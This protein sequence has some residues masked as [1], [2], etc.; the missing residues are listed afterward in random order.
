VPTEQRTNL[1][2]IFEDRLEAE[3]A[4]DELEQAGFS[5][6]EV[7][8]AIRGSDV[9]AGGMITDEE[10]A[11]DARGAAAGMATGAGV[12]AVL[13]AAAALLVPGVGPVVAAGVL[14]MAFG[15]AI[16]GT[17]IGGIFGALTGLDVSEDEARLY[18]HEFNSGKA[19]VAVKAATR[20]RDAARILKNHGGYDLQN[21]P[22]G[23]VPTEGVFSQP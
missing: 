17:A 14:G 19:I 16:A 1:V 8:F 21:R 5:S 3:R 20:C 6:D 12:G 4:V 22:A 23:D 10:G 13:G 7:G 18:E 15:G 2:A 11:K 9:A